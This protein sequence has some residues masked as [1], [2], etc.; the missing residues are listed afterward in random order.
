MTPTFWHGRRVFV[1]GHTGFK[2][3]WLSL[4]L[5]QMGAELTGYALPPAT[6]PNLF[7]VAGVERGMRSIT[8]D[9]R[10]LP[11]LQS[12]MQ[13]AQPEVVLHLAAQ[14]LVRPGYADPVGTYASNVMGTVHLCEAVRQTPSVRAVV[15]VTS[16]KCYANQEWEWA[17]RESDPMGGHD[18]YSASKGCSELVAA[19]YR[20]AYFPAGEHARHGVALGTA[21]AGNVMGGGDWS[22]DRLLPDLLRAADQDEAVSIRH[23]DATRPWQHVLDALAGYLLLAERLHAQGPRH[24][25]AWNFGPDEADVR[26]VRQIVAQLQRQLPL[27]AEFAT[28][29]TGPHEAQALRLDSAKARH[30]LGWRPA[31]TLDQALGQLVNWHLAWRQH[32]DMRGVCTEQID[33]HMNHFSKALHP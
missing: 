21:R 32:Q 1:T 19:S 2:G 3:A 11:A 7:D 5:Q 13:Q 4:W 25:G 14:A 12:A 24:A 15:C 28:R 17:Y 20:D 27:K 22:A 18:P 8:G 29:S 26:S 31:W 30:R 10:D 6:S 16:D 23:P 33:N 9:V